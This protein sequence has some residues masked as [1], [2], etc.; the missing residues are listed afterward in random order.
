MKLNLIALCS[1]CCTLLNGNVFAEKAR[2]DKD[3][4]SKW[5]VAAESGDLETMKSLY[6]SYDGHFEWGTTLETAVEKGYADVVAWLDPII[7][8]ERAKGWNIFNL[9]SRNKKGEPMMV[10]ATK[11]GHEEVLKYMLSKPMDP[12]LYSITNPDNS[13]DPRIYKNSLMVAAENGFTNIVD[14]L[15]K[16]NANPNRRDLRDNTALIYASENGHVDIV[17]LLLENGAD[18]DKKNRAGLTALMYAVRNGHV[19]IAKILLDHGARIDR[20]SGSKK[21]ALDYARGNIEMT[22]LLA[23]YKDRPENK[24]KPGLIKRTWNK[25]KNK[26]DGE[27]GGLN[28]DLIKRTRNEVTD[29][30]TDENNNK[31]VKY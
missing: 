5:T 31:R 26:S 10:V 22:E 20:T 13:G 25:I 30:I 11:N 9:E 24:K 15:L 17:K 2:C 6:K 29:E 28:K 7:E 3:C 12:D 4:Y 27:K 21:T 16:N 23:E 14:L 1:V 8:Q 18:P 19:N